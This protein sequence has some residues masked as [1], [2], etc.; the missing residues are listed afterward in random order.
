MALKDY[1]D[2]VLKYKEHNKEIRYLNGKYYL[3]KVHTSRIDGKVKKYTDA[4]LGRITENG[5][6]SP[7]KK[8]VDYIVKEYSSF[9]FT[10]NV[11]KS[12]ITSITSKYPIKSKDYLCNAIFTVIFDNNLNKW[13]KSYF[14]I[15]FPDFKLIKHTEKVTLEINRIITMMKYKIDKFLDQQ[16]L[17][18]FLESI[19]DLYMVGVKDNYT[20]ATISKE[21]INIL[22]NNKFELEI[23]Y[24]KDK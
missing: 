24:G 20:L 5:L 17:S 16:P 1:P 8:H 14:S 11:C 18:S 3:Y 13:N 9:C 7:V 4:Y 6:I 22:H 2:W 12:V 10:F 23:N 19:N 21:T 15:I